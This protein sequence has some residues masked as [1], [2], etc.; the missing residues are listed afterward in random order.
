MDFWNRVPDDTISRVA[1]QQ[2][3]QEQRYGSVFVTKSR[4]KKQFGLDQI[5]IKQFEK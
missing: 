3:D 5:S 1:F 2:V 4:L